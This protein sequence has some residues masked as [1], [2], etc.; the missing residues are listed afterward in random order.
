MSLIAYND[1]IRVEEGGTGRSERHAV[2]DLIFLILLRIPLE[3]YPSHCLILTS[4]IY[5]AI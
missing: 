4:Y 3:S 1:S 5:N 2:L